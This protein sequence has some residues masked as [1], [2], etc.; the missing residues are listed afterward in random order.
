MEIMLAILFFSLIGAICLRLFVYSHQLTQRSEELSFAVE[1]ISSIAVLLEHADTPEDAVQLLQSQYN[2]DDDL[3]AY[4]D[5]NY[6][7]CAIADASYTITI[8]G[9]G[10]SLHTWHLAAARLGDTEPIYNLELEV[11]YGA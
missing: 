1:Q 3:S 5:D 2:T 11:Y 10:S 7:L 4:F 9:E 6:S 8:S